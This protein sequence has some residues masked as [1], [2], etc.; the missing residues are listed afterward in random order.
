MDD[1][2]NLAETFLATHYLVQEYHMAWYKE[3]YGGID[4]KYGQGRILSVLSRINAAVSQKELGFIMNMR[5]QTLGELLQKLE[6]N[7]YIERYRSIRDKR[8]LIVI[9]TEKGEQFQKSR[10]YYEELF[11]EMSE[12]ERETLKC[13]LQKVDV[14][15]ESLLYP[16]APETDEKEQDDTDDNTDEDTDDKEENN[17]E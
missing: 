16:S 1:T 7:G 15:L 17:A 3:N 11:C 9:L 14:R 5:P 12:E 8:S 6:A 4:P 2:K 10:P 13:L